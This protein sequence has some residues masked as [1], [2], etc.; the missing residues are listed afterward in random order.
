MEQ[1]VENRGRQ[2][3]VAE[4]GAP[5]R[6]DL[7][8]GDQQTATLVPTRHKLEKEMGAAAFKRQVSELVDDQ[9]LRLAVKQQALGELAFALGFHERGEQGRRAREEHRVAGFDDGTAECDREMG[10]ADARRAKDKNVFCL[11]EKSCG[12]ELADESLID[13]RLEFEIEV[14]ERFDRRK[15]GDFQPHRDAGPLLRVHFLTQ[16]A[17]EK[18][19]IRRLAARGITKD[20]VQALGHVA[21]T[22]ARQ[23]LDHTR[24]DD[25]HDAPPVMTAA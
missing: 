11:R 6:H 12:R 17:V 4:D 14:V 23:L 21:E 20:S 19:E 3:V 25:A 18:V 1:A 2:D 7:I 8:R 5:L 13:G 9:Q 22:E 10:L 15:V 16:Y 24:V